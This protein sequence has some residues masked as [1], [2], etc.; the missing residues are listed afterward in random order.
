MQ[1]EGIK[2]IHIAFF[3]TIIGQYLGDSLESLLKSG[4]GR[5]FELEN[6]LLLISYKIDNNYVNR[7]K[8]I[9]NHSG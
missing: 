1:L 7:P 3:I 2:V 8:L 5:H 6:F 4:G 9:F